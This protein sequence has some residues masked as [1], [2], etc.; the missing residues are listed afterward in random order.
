MDGPFRHPSVK[1][2][3]SGPCQS[4]SLHYSQSRKTFFMGVANGILESCGVFEQC[5]QND[6][7]YVIDHR[8]NDIAPI[9]RLQRPSPLV[10]ADHTLSS[11]A[12]PLNQFIVA[13]LIL[14]ILIN[15]RP[16]L[17]LTNNQPNLNR[18][19]YVKSIGKRASR[20]GSILFCHED[21]PIR[22]QNWI[23][24]SDYC[25]ESLVWLSEVIRRA[26]HVCYQPTL[27]Y[28]ATC[29]LAAHRGA[30]HRKSPH[31]TQFC[32]IECCCLESGNFFWHHVQTSGPLQGAF[33]EAVEAR[34]LR[35][36]IANGGREP[37]L[38]GFSRFGFSLGLFRCESSQS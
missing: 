36:V 32:F 17:F 14:S 5:R 11:A 15:R 2:L 13:A 38:R 37:R 27:I 29:M 26:I 33:R 16:K 8:I 22:I 12:N 18:K 35:R 9:R 21:E 19:T 24:S 1:Q 31:R 4:A 3:S 10:E 25:E 23:E 20:A 28:L 34:R 30:R 7:L 6:F